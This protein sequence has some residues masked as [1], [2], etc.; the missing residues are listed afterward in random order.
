[1]S[2][3]ENSCRDGELVG[4]GFRGA[5]VSEE[6]AGGRPVGVVC[7]AFRFGRGELDILFRAG[8]ENGRA[9]V[10]CDAGW[11]HVRRKIA[12]T[13]FVSLDA[14]KAVAGSFAKPRGDGREREGQTDARRAGG[15]T[16]GFSARD[17]NL[18]QCEENGCVA[19][20]TFAGFLATET[21][22]ERARAAHR[23]AEWIR[24][25]D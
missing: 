21:R 1:M 2:E 11:F 22:V 20:A 6:T 12:S 15:A 13:V 4:S 16:E 3:R 23:D 19:S 5:L 24:A 25:G 9:V 14:G 8:A 18:S 10:R 7:A 17:R